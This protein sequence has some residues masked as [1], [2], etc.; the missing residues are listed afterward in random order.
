MLTAT[1]DSELGVRALGAI[2][3]CLS[4]SLLDHQLLS[5]AHF[6]VY[7]PIDMATPQSDSGSNMD[8]GTKHMVKQFLFNF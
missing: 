5:M 4:R 1:D 2:V 7:V 3:W 8:I 6:E